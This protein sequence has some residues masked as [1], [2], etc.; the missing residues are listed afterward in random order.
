MSRWILVVDDEPDVRSALSEL[1]SGQGYSVST[2][3][4]GHEALWI[5]VSKLPDLII[6]DLRMPRQNGW[7]FLRVMR[8]NPKALN[9]PVVVL[10]ADLS[11]PPVGG[12]VWLKKP[13]QPSVLLKAIARLV[14]RSPTAENAR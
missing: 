13:V 1:L 2:A 14:E 9:V 12:D 5:M 7:E 10:S 3:A 4:D 11:M 6:L 8:A